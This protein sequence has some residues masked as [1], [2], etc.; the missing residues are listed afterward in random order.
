MSKQSKI[1]ILFVHGIG[2]Q[3]RRDTLLRFGEPIIK[4][5]QEHIA[6]EPIEED[7]ELFT[8]LGNVKVQHPSFIDSV[9]DN[10]PESITVSIELEEKSSSPTGKMEW[11]L[12]ETWWAEVFVSPKFSSLAFWVLT[13]G[14]W[15]ALTHIGQRAKNEN[16]GV[17]KTVFKWILAWVVSFIVQIITLILSVAAILPIPKFR[18]K[19]T[20]VLSL[21]TATLGDAYVLIS[22]PVQRAAAMQRVQDG[23]DWL[24]NK[25]KCDEVVVIAH[26]QGAAIAAEKLAEEHKDV[27]LFIT[28]GSG[29]AKLT[30]LN[31]LYNSRIISRV[32]NDKKSTFKRF[33]VTISILFT[34]VFFMSL[35]AVPVLM[36][37]LG[38]YEWLAYIFNGYIFMFV[39]LLYLSTTNI[40]LDYKNKLEK[41]KNSITNGKTRWINIYSSHDPVSNGP[42]K[43][44]ITTNF[45]EYEVVNE[46]TLFGDH[47]LYWQNIDG[48][49]AN[50][51][52]QIDRLCQASFIYKYKDVETLNTIMNVIDNSRRERVF[53][54][55]INRYLLPVGF[56]LFVS[57]LWKDLAVWSK[58]SIL[59]L[60]SQPAF[61]WVGN[62]FVQIEVVFKS[63]LLFIHTPLTYVEVVGSRLIGIFYLLLGFY[64]WKR[65]FYILWTVYDRNMARASS[66]LYLD[67]SETSVHKFTEFNKKV[68]N[69]LPVS[70][71]GSILWVMIL[72]PVVIG[73]VGIFNENP[74]QFWLTLLQYFEYSVIYIIISGFVMLIVFLSV[75]KIKDFRK[76]RKR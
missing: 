61:S 67:E 36:P 3:P 1:G 26:S 54:L 6:D 44:E 34:P 11:I 70:K 52:Y 48:F 22:S 75:L 24:K 50:I 40:L 17:L 63:I 46:K 59:F 64:V 31:E 32:K 41:M 39:V 29:I 23:I 19:L 65:G 73:A 68:I 62:I 21:L 76:S 72:L 9:N 30:Q 10:I 60:D 42:L 15:V 57:W 74:T 5:L 18:E 13:V 51:V 12:A 20:E 2:D 16:Y 7:R 66:L 47:T 4:I 55:W 69:Q 58:N 53:L 37:F 38:N 56:L 43:L 27:D 25:C 71:L 33:V 45:S 8:R 35:L 14:P 28:Y 49:V